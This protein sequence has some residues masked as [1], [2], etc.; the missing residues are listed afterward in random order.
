MMNEIKLRAGR[1]AGVGVALA[2]AVVGKTAL[3]APSVTFSATEAGGIIDTLYD[4]AVPFVTTYV[5]II[6]LLAVLVGLVWYFIRKLKGGLRG[7]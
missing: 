2:T 5:P 6:A 7:R 1:I 4:G 3:M